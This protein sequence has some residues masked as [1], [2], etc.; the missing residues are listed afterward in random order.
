MKTALFG[1]LAMGIAN[2]VGLACI[3]KEKQHTRQFVI[4]CTEDRVGFGEA[5]EDEDVGQA[6]ERILKHQQDS[7]NQL[8]APHLDRRGNN[9]F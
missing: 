3:L 2:L 8:P 9:T 1:L 5:K 7:Q 6:F 4:I